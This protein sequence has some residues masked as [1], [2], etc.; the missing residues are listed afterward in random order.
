M[1]WVLIVLSGFVGSV[2]EIPTTDHLEVSEPLQVLR[3][4]STHAALKIT[5]TK[6]GNYTATLYHFDK[7][8]EHIHVGTGKQ[9]S[10]EVLAAPEHS[11]DTVRFN[12][13]I[14]LLTILS[15]LGIVAG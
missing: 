10:V 11:T 13:R 9:I 14:F 2:H 1:I 7:Q 5:P 12:L 4:N 3:Q 15:K 6:P 8:Q